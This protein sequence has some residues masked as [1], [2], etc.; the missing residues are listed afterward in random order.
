MSEKS[1]SRS[2]TP[3][4]FGIALALGI[5]IGDKLNS[6]HELSGVNKMEEIL[7]FI[8]SNYVDTLNINDTQDKDIEALLQQLDP[9]SA[10]IPAADLKNV[11]EDLEGNF[12]GIGVE[13]RI[14]NDTIVVLKVIADGPSEKAGLHDG[15]RIIKVN[16]KNIASIKITNK[17]VMKL[18]KGESGTKVKVTVFRKAAGKSLSYDI[19]RGKIPL[20]SV[21]TS[22][23][24]NKEIGYI[25]VDRFAEHTYDEFIEAT[26]RLKKSGMTKLIIDVRNNPGGY[27]ETAVDIVDEMIAGE[28][29]VVYTEGKNRKKQEYKTSKK[30]ILEDIQIEVLVNESSASAAEILA[31]ALQDWD[32]ATII[33]RRSF[34][35]GLVQEQTPI[36]DGSAIRLTVARYYIPSGRC[37]QKSYAGG[38]EKY[39]E[40]F[41]DRENHGELFSKDSMKIDK[42]K[43]FKTASGKTVYG[44]GGIIPDYFVPLDT[45]FSSY[46][47]N[48]LFAMNSFSDF[49]Y[50]YADNNMVKL[51]SFE[52]PLDFVANY[53][54][55]DNLL[56]DFIHY[57]TTHGVPMDQ[58]GYNRS[59]PEIKNQLKSL[60]ARIA[61]DDE[62]LYR[63]INENDA[64]FN[65]AVELFK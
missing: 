1:N 59:K 58:K 32:R 18:L 31:G 52:G 48:K 20:Y 47:L 53:T 36:N 9:H 25:L 41:S 19:K 54:I 63:T 38:S 10:Y 11:N 34:G 29:M 26:E 14:I 37:I 16:N 15:D 43:A 56:N 28:K 40:D 23:M 45:S 65:K 51:K 33:G 3:F 6:R 60:F 55:T 7:N 46:Y 62:G 64:T 27:L 30:G 4:V 8:N 35:K 61:W 5:Y 12:E 39:Y 22:Y 42:S 50:N 2:W 17:D 49:C 13:F 24:Y 21:T 44:G 57:A